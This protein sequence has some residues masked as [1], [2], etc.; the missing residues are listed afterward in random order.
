MVVHL[1]IWPFSSPRPLGRSAPVVLRLH[2]R[3]GAWWELPFCS[4]GS[5]PQDWASRRKAGA[6]EP[7]WPPG[8][9]ARR[10]VPVCERGLC[11][12]LDPEL[13]SPPAGPRSLARA[14]GIPVL[15]WPV[16]R[17]SFPGTRLVF[18][19]FTASSRPRCSEPLVGT[20][21]S[22]GCRR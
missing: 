1:T 12:G 8:R 2:G 15:C 13:G 21:V 10:Q 14:S 19:L 4:G 18:W 7:V 16:D 5:V 17:H 20:V 22:E 3:A 9:P 11:S 6:A